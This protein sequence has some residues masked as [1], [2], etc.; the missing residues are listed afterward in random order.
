M[1][2]ELSEKLQSGK[3]SY[4]RKTRQ[5]HWIC[6][7][8][9]FQNTLKARVVPLCIFFHDWLLRM[10]QDLLQQPPSLPYIS[11]LGSW[12]L[13]SVPVHSLPLYF[14]GNVSSTFYISQCLRSRLNTAGPWEIHITATLGNT[15]HVKCF[16]T[17]TQWSLHPPPKGIWPKSSFFPP[18]QHV[19]QE[20]KARLR[21]RKALLDSDC[22]LWV[23]FPAVFVKNVL[24]CSPI[25]LPDLQPPPNAYTQSHCSPS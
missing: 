13:S 14:E 6:C 18:T 16:P 21:A 23:C 19:K 9:E 12:T 7:E 4:F 5:I 15:L 22:V 11:A 1:P 8:L 17:V 2:H 24:C 20:I 3:I 25:S 10:L